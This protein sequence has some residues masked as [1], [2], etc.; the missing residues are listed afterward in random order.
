MTA[1]P[2]KLERRVGSGQGRIMDYTTLISFVIGTA[3][4][5]LKQT[6]RT[7]ASPTHEWAV[8]GQAPEPASPASAKAADEPSLV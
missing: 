5:A 3:I 1:M 8:L 7:L 2:H 6:R 4:G